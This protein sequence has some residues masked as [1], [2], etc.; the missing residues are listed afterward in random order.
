[1]GF[2][3]PVKQKVHG[4]HCSPEKQFQSISTFVQSYVYIVTL[5]KRQQIISPFWGLNGPLLIHSLHTRML[6]AKLSWN[7]PCCSREE[8]FLIIIYP[9][10]GN[11]PLFHQTWIPFT[12]GCFVPSLIEIGPVVLEKKVKM[13][14]VSR[15]M[16]NMWPEKLTWTFSLDELKSNHKV[17]ICNRKLFNY[18]FGETSASNIIDSRCNGSNVAFINLGLM[19]QCCEPH[20]FRSV[21]ETAKTEV[22]CHSCCVTWSLFCSKVVS[23]EKVQNVAELHRQ[24]WPH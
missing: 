5:K 17:W 21:G 23:T 19:F 18:W 7:L 22:P 24:W 10:E 9:W 15:R 6:C 1:M 3:L 4:P 13:W 12:Q 20:G 11:C 8:G 16:D 2:I 14:K